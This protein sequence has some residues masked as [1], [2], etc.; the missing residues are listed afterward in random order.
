M[1][2]LG[3]P[4][5]YLWVTDDK[6]LLLLLIGHFRPNQHLVA[7]QFQRVDWERLLVDL[8]LRQAQ[9]ALVNG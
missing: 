4:I 3:I 2:N 9:L 6:I 7:I 5:D 1:E 8:H